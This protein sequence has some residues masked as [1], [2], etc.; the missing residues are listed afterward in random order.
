IQSK[1]VQADFIGM[2]KGVAALKSGLNML[3]YEAT[4]PRRPTRPLSSDEKSELR[5]AFETAE[6]L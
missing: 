4:V 5:E 2:D 6:I 1:I 3:G